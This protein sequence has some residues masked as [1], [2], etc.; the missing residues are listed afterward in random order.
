MYTMN[1]LWTAGKKQARQGW[2]AFT[3]AYD[4]THPIDPAIA[5]GYNQA[6]AI[7]Q[8]ARRLPFTDPVRL[9]ID[10]GSQGGYAALAVSADLFP[11]TS[12]TPNAPVV[13]WSYNL[14]YFEANRAV[15][16]YP[17]SLDD[18]PLPVV[19]AVTML[20]DWCYKFFGEDLSAEAYYRVSPIA[21][22]GRIANPVLLTC[23]TGDMLVPMEQMTRGPLPPYDPAKFPEGYQRD[24]ETLTP[25]VAARKTFEECIPEDRREVFTVPRQEDS[26]ELTLEMF[27]DPKAKPK[28]RPKSQEKPWSKNRQ[29]SLVYCD[30]GPPVPQAGHVSWEWN[31]SNN[32]FIRHHK[33]API[34]AGNLERRKAALACAA[35]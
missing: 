25:C 22:L 3:A 4:E 14:N 33:T 34:G 35:A 19:C 12:A 6:R 5:N 10:G 30:E 7:V 23:A 8:W 16:K 21:Y 32:D 18:S 29:W 31:L 11:V 9:H 26:F 28:K 27:K 24:F 13:N 1:F 2:A 20:A 15:S 17:S